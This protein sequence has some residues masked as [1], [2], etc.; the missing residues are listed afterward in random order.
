M[1]KKQTITLLFLLYVNTENSFKNGGKGGK[2][3]TKGMGE[4]ERL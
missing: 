1:Y 2:G 4:T 3:Q